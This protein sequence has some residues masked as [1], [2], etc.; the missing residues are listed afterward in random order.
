[1]L[2]ELTKRFHGNV[3]PTQ[4]YAATVSNV[5]RVIGPYAHTETG[6]LEYND[7]FSRHFSSRDSQ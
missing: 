2:S 1:M 7:A 3:I 4:Q 6:C 5:Q